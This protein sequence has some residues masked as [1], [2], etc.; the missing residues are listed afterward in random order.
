MA[1]RCDWCNKE[2][3]LESH[4]DFTGTY[5]LCTSCKESANNDECVTCKQPLYGELAIKGECSTC[6][7]V[8]SAKEEKRRSEIMN[9]LGQDVISELTHSVTF[10]EE[11]YDN[12]VTF[13][14]GNFTP[15][16]RKLA[17]RNWMYNRLVNIAGWSEDDFDRN[18]EDIEYLMDNFSHKIFNSRYVFVLNNGNTKGLRGLNII[19]SRGNVMVVEK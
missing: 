10:T 3:H 17:R 9:G 15:Q 8:R 14:Q 4:E 19:E 11:D 6:Q 18:F 16:A 2:E 5:N 7:Q 13:G 1:G 12:W